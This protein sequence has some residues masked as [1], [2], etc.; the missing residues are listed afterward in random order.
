MLLTIVAP[1][2]Y[3]PRQMTPAVG[4]VAVGTILSVLYLCNVHLVFAS[5]RSA[6]L[7][8]V[9]PMSLAVGTAGALLAGHY[10]GVAAVG[11]GM[12][13][14]YAAMALGVARLA[15]RVSPTRW[16][17]RALLGPLLWGFALC[18]VGAALPTDGGWVVLRLALAAGMLVV[19]LWV[20]RRVLTR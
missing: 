6:G 17:E 19:S 2:S 16:R 5:G 3:N 13:I 9:T 7:A 20:L 10:L 4:L 18:A 11:V 14:T 12:T 1:A 8:L 15:R